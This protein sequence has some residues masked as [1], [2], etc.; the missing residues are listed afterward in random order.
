MADLNSTIVRGNLRVT[1]EIIGPLNIANLSTGANGQFLSIS[2]NVP[3]WVNNPNTNTWRPIK[4]DGTVKLNQWTSSSELN[5][6][7][8]NNMTITESGGT[9]TFAATDTNTWRPLGTGANDA[10]AGNHSHDGRY[11]LL[12][13]GTLTGALNFNNSTWNLVG[14]DVYIGDYDQAGSL[15]VRGKNGQTNIGFVNQ[16]NNYYIKLASPGVTANRT[17]TMPDDTGTIALTKN[18]PTS[19]PANGGNADTVDGKHSSDFCLSNSNITNL[20]INGGIYWNSY[21]ESSNDGSDAASITVIRDGNGSGGTVLQIKQAND[22]NDIVNVVAGDLKLNGVSVSTHGHDHDDRYYTESEVNSKLDGKSNTGHTHDDRYYT[23]S[24]MNTKLNGKSDTGHTHA[25]LPLSGGVVTG[26]TS[27]N[28]F[29]RLR[30]SSYGIQFNT[31]N[32]TVSNMESGSVSMAVNTTSGYVNSKT[33]TFYDG[34]KGMGSWHI[35]VTPEKSYSHYIVVGTTNISNT[36]FTILTRT[37]ANIPPSQGQMNF[38]YV[39]VKYW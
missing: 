1:E 31:A 18:I 35:M 11:L 3:T 30:S 8:G 19:L 22:N 24:E 20:P 9:F 13:G 7:A 27:F 37:I 17:I 32:Y 29:L 15:G 6:Q 23:K 4:L 12:G 5:I 25:Y 10:A 33:V 21:V 14:D 28:D 34:A 36:G 38:H 39:A 2:N 26:E 16:S